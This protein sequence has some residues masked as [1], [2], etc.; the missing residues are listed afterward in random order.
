MSRFLLI[1]LLGAFFSTASFAACVTTNNLVICDKPS[2]NNSQNSWQSKPSQGYSDR[3]DRYYNNNR[4]DDR[5]CNQTSSR[6]Q[7]W[8]KPINSNHWNRPSSS[9]LVPGVRYVSNYDERRNS[10]YC[11]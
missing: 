10:K 5:C 8:G 1:G 4:R 6:P 3:Y 2:Y 7:T 11:R 9:K